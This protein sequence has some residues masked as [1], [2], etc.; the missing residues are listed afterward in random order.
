M[1]ATIPDVRRSL[2]IW[3][4]LLIGASPACLL[5]LDNEISCG[6]GVVDVRAGEECDPAV[7]SSFEDACSSPLATAACDPDTCMIIDDFGECS[8]CG[9]GIV[10]A[11]RGEECDGDELGGEVCP[12]GNGALRCGSEC[13]LDYSEC[14]ACGNGVVDEGEECDYNNVGGFATERPCAGSPDEEVPPLSAPTKPFRSG[15]TTVCREDCRWD[16]SGC[17]FCGDGVQDDGIP[18]QEG[19]SSPPE[20]CDGERFSDPRLITEFGPLCNDPETQRPAVTCGDDCRSFIE[21]DNGCCL[22]HNAACPDSGIG[23]PGGA[24]GDDDGGTDGDGPPPVPCCWAVANPDGGD[25][26][27]NSFESD[28][29]LRR[30]C[31]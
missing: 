20:W 9:D 28:G 25:P 8:V 6:D 31:R 13:L 21:I 19:V 7:P 27:Y 3:A 14:D 1:R 22:R 2:A 24:G 11:L 12:G 4:A 26:C 23:K 30:L 29:G 17:G 18:L 15:S 5:Q 10:D 16:R